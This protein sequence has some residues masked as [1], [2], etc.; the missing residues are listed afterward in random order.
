MLDCRVARSALSSGWPSVDLDVSLE[1]VYVH[2]GSYVDIPFKNEFV[3]RLILIDLPNRDIIGEAVKE[4]QRVIHKK[5][6]ISILTP[7]ILI[8]GHDDPLTIGDFV[9]KNE[10]EIREKGVHINRKVLF[11]TLESLFQKVVESEALH[12]SIISAH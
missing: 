3:D 8:Q 4:W 11:S 1:N 9:E 12:M 6:R 5:G 2:N 10:H 7:T